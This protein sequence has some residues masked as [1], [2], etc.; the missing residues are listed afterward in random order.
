MYASVAEVDY[1]TNDTVNTRQVVFRLH[2]PANKS[3]GIASDSTYTGHNLGERGYYYDWSQAAAACAELG[4]EWA[5][6]DNT[7][8][9]A[10]SNALQTLTGG[11]GKWIITAIKGTLVEPRCIRGCRLLW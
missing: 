10:L 2:D 8:W 4:P 3:Q 11:T 9:S 6:P 1:L 5:V 7:Q